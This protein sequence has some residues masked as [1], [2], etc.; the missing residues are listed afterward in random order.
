MV[1]SSPVFLF[2]FLPLTLLLVLLAGDRKRQNTLLLIASLFFYAWG[3]KSW[4]LLMVGTALFNH[5]CGL[6][7]ERWRSPRAVLA[8]AVFANLA[9]LIW[10][11][12]ANLFAT[13]I[14]ALLGSDILLLD[15]VHL[16]IG[17]SSSS[18]T[19]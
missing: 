6:A 2:Q 10:F 16:P 4:V 9:V 11:K 15:P 18:S 1:F 14:N 17:V 19:A 12:Y 3:E 8:L 7:I 5:L 13:T